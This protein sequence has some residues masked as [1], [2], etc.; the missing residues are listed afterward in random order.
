MPRHV[1]AKVSPTEGADVRADLDLKREELRRTLATN[2]ALEDVIT[3]LR[4]LQLTLHPPSG[5]TPQ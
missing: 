2:Q 1:P 5:R 3:V 4:S